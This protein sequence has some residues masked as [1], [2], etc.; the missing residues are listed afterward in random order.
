MARAN[1]NYEKRKR[2]AAKQ[3]KRLEKRLRK[4]AKREGRIDADGNP[5]IDPEAVA[6]NPSFADPADAPAP[7]GMIA[8]EPTETFDAGALKEAEPAEDPEDSEAPEA[9]SDEATEEEAPPA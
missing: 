3:K 2:E 9:P 4:K 1:Y 6:G 8:A 7:T 5:I